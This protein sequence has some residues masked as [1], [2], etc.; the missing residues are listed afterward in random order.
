MKSMNDYVS[1]ARSA[2]DEIDAAQAV[3]ME[4]GLLLDVREP[5]ELA[6]TGK[7]GGAVHIPRGLLEANA[8]PDSPAASGDL[9]V[10]RGTDSPVLVYCASGARGALATRTLCEMGYNAKNIK[11]GIAAWKAA[12]GSVEHN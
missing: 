9:T 4:G 8:D 12:G 3:S 1:D 2:I 5:G 6:E 10:C 11:G 7:A